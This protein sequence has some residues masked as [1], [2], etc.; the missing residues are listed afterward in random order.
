M[1]SPSA[2]EQIHTTLNGQSQDIITPHRKRA[3]LLLEE[4]DSCVRLGCGSQGS[5]GS[6]VV[7][8]KGRPRM[9]CTLRAKNLDRKVVQTLQGIPLSRRKEILQSFLNVGAG[10]CG[11]CMPGIITQVHT[12]LSNIEHPTVEQINKALSL[13]SCRCLSP[14]LLTDAVNNLIEKV[15]TEHTPAPSP[16]YN[17]MLGLSHTL[18]EFTLPEM[19]VAHPL[20]TWDTQHA[21]FELESHALQDVHIV[22]RSEIPKEIRDSHPTLLGFLLSADKWTAQ[23]TLETYALGRAPTSPSPYEIESNE[24]HSKI[25]LPYD[26]APLE[27]EVCV[28]AE[29]VIRLNG[30]ESS[31]LS[32]R[33]KSYRIQQWKV[34]GSFG[35]RSFSDH[36][37]W[38]VWLHEH[39]NVPV[40]L[41]MSMAQ[42]L[43]LRPKH[44][45]VEFAYTDPFRI[46]LRVEQKTETELIS[47]TKKL[48]Q[49][50]Q[51]LTELFAE[52][53]HP[54][55]PSG[56]TVSLSHRQQPN[57]HIQE[58]A[59]EVRMAQVSAL[60]LESLFE[61][62]PDPIDARLS[63]LDH[64][65]ATYNLPTEWLESVRAHAQM[66]QENTELGWG[67]SIVPQQT[68]TLA[69]PMTGTLTVFEESIS[70]EGSRRSAT[71]G[72]GVPITNDVQVTTIQS[73]VHRLTNIPMDQI[74]YTC[75]G[76]HP[77]PMDDPSTLRAHCI[78]AV[79]ELCKQYTQSND[80]Q[81]YEHAHQSL[82]MPTSVC[83]V[84]LTIDEKGNP[85]STWISIPLDEYTPLVQTQAELSGRW[86]RSLGREQLWHSGPTPTGLFKDLH[87]LKSK[88][89]ISLNWTT[90]ESSPSPTGWTTVNGATMA[91]IT[92]A[93]RKV[94]LPHTVVPF[95]K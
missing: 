4:Q 66:C 8:V 53:V 43:R 39:V 86:M 64:V 13:H 73:L 61:R 84:L 55:S 89:A 71:V 69:Q 40:S 63:F 17:E 25:L 72:L 52:A 2:S 27:S 95:T 47:W 54:N 65:V 22:S 42:M 20:F 91:A 94:G 62:E 30:V 93:R 7:V 58:R 74:T 51:Q 92:N 56:M 1:T 37:D 34:G 24:L 87:T 23:Q 45:F 14:H 15:R 50:V 31:D 41:Q 18:K 12:L 59:S 81:T 21:I 90:I 44:P 46:S 85:S 5:C 26:D 80:T 38:A 33:F 70:D 29:G 67:L 82:E 11:Y 79:T 68:H 83:S 9:S 60:L 48:Q 76:D 19:H 16:F 75:G 35:S 6:C 3:S 36:V 78:H 88:D 57:S 49:H 28:V 32:K 10:Q 77:S